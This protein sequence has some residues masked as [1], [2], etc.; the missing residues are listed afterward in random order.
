VN[1]IR[2]KNI[3]SFSKSPVNDKMGLGELY[4]NY[5]QGLKAYI[6]SK[7]RNVDHEEV[8]QT[9]FLKM[10]QRSNLEEIEHPKGYLYRAVDHVIYDDNRRRQVQNK[11][12]EEINGEGHFFEEL[13]PERIVA[14]KEELS[15]ITHAI[16][17]MSPK[18]QRLLILYRISGLS[19]AAIAR[20]T[21]MPARTVQRNV[22]EAIRELDEII[23]LMKNENTDEHS[24]I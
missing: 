23:C 20:T 17:Q 5:R 16:K 10:A 6:L 12:I 4:E 14:G 24:D 22:S 1:E 9:V 3:A 2:L 13:T 8:I 11:Y 21:R 15:L 18:K 19:Y 7:F